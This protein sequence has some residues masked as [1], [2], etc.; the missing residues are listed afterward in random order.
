MK[1]NFIPHP[2]VFIL[3]LL[4]HLTVAV[5]AHAQTPYYQG[6]TMTIVVG[7]VAGDI[8]DLYARAI[9]LTMGK[10]LPGNPNIIV[11]NMPGAG[12]MIAANYLYGVAKPDGLTIAGILPTLY[13]E[14]LIGRAEVKFDWTKFNWIGNATKSPQVLY[15]RADA[16]YKT[17]DDVR[18]AKEPPKCGTTG[19]SNM[20]YFVP[21]LLNETIGAK[22]NVIA[23]YQGGSEVDLAV[24]KGE[25]QCRSLSAEAFFSR[26]PFHTWRKKGF[27]RVLAY[28]GKSRGEKLPDAPTVYELLDK[29]NTPELGRRLATA[30]L[31]AGEFHRP[32]IGPPNLRPEHVKMLREAFDKT[33]KDPGF[34]A[35]AA[36][37]KLDI[38]PTTG[39]EV[40]VLIKEVM[41][42]PKDV[43][44]RLK[45]LMGR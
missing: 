36:K 5:Q 18:N 34:L 41:S 44:E 11:Q 29:Y 45:V 28:G 35:E 8:Y 23:G 15:M 3:F 4:L 12:H 25:I 7:T 6:K 21:K 19:T 37:K 17:M 30:L 16:P 42:Q 27:V 10:Y 38:D 24:E 43:I 31:A 1:R 22:F 32:Y 39:A 40:E 9:A 33:M 20:G 26:E 13:F 2:S 14:Q